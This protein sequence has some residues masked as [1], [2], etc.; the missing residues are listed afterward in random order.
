MKNTL[1]IG[2]MILVGLATTAPALADCKAE[3]VKVKNLITEYTRK[4][5]SGAY[6]DPINYGGAVRKH[7]YDLDNDEYWVETPFALEG[8]RFASGFSSATLR[9]SSGSVARDCRV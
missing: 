4:V 6:V 2:L 8:G 7:L 1:L 3:Q 5:K 9:R